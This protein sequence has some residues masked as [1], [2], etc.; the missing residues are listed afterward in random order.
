MRLSFIKPVFRSSWHDKQR[1]HTFSHFLSLIYS[2]HVL[3]LTLTWPCYG[4]IT[5]QSAAFDPHSDVGSVY[6]KTK[7][8]QLRRDTITR[9][10]GSCPLKHLV[11]NLSYDLD[12]LFLQYCLCYL[13]WYLPLQIEYSDLW[14]MYY[15]YVRITTLIW[16]IVQKGAPIIL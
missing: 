13:D 12:R 5:N 4:I 3:S 10:Q 2:T 8:L 11:I 14:P 6:I 15:S 7:C 16:T 9:D 1:F